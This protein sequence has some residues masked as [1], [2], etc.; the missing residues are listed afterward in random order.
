MAGLYFFANFQRVGVPSAVFDEVQSDFHVSAS[1]VTALAAVFLYV[2]AGLQLFVGAG[3][4]RFGPAKMVLTGGALLAAGS[5]LFPFAGSMTTLYLCRALVGLGASFM[6]LSIVKEIVNIF[7]A[8]LFAPLLGML[9]VIGYTGGLAA[10]APLQRGVAAYGWRAPFVAA[11]IACLVVYI[12]VAIL[13]KGSGRLGR[14]RSGLSVASVR[15]LLRTKSI[16]PILLSG[17][18][19]F[20]LYYVLQITVGKKFLED[21][22]NLSSKA[23]ANV[24][25]AMLFTVVVGYLVG[26]FLPRLAGNRR[27][28]FVIATSVG[29]LAGSAGLALGI[30]IGAGPWCFIASYI[31][32]AA[33]NTSALIGTALLKEVSRP[34][35]AAF[36]VGILNAASYACVAVA[37]NAA[38]LVLDAFAKDA[39]VTEKAVIYPAAAYGWMFAGMVAFS[40]VSL[41]ASF[42]VPETLGNQ[43][44]ED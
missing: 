32:L 1:A 3:A 30:V 23:A 22:C 18:I 7:E 20:A 28:P 5:I 6:Y 15:V 31:I 42:F 40:V 2:Y 4:D 14:E 10:T 8:R 38:G 11:G 12:F 16:Y 21:Y 34:R 19:N 35:T 29:V 33:T 24:T 25:F 27:R 41:A 43:S 44:A 13:L 17:A 26:G 9:L 37:S 36:A 39:R